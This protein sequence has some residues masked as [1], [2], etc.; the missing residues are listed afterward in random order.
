MNFSP[1]ILILSL[2]ILIIGLIAI[3][4]NIWFIL[5]KKQHYRKLTIPIKK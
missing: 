4:P 1:S 5:L 2:I 3:I